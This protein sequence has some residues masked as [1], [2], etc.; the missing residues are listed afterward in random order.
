MGGA[1]LLV[2]LWRVDCREVSVS[3]EVEPAPGV[4]FD[5]EMRLE[6]A[7]RGYDADAGD[8]NAILTGWVVVAEWIDGDGD[9]NLT[10]FAREGMPSWR[11]NGLL[12]AA[13]FEIVYDDEDF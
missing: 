1:S 9:P 13:P 12:E 4:L 2:D 8:G 5:A 10:A 7:I 6:E 3:D 11:I